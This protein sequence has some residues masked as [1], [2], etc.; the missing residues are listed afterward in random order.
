MYQEASE[1]NKLRLARRRQ[2]R[3]RAAVEAVPGRDDLGFLGVN[4]VRVLARDLDGALVGLG[5]R[6]AEERL[7]ESRER[8]ELRRGVGLRLRVVEVRAVDELLRLLGD[9]R[10]E[11]P[12][13]VAEHVHGDAA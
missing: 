12:V 7:V 5:A 8:D 10:D 3:D 2:R 4:L 1:D 13:I 11:R 6:V 9:G